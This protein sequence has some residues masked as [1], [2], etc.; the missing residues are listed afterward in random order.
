MVRR[1]N[2]SGP[3]KLRFRPVLVG[4][5]HPM[6]HS[7]TGEVG[8]FS[9]Q[10]GSSGLNLRW[11]LS[12][13]CKWKISYPIFIGEVTRSASLMN[14]NLLQPQLLGKALLEDVIIS[15]LGDK[16]SAPIEKVAGGPGCRSGVSKGR[17]DRRRHFS[18]AASG[19][20][21]LESP[22]SQGGSRSH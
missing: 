5:G 21:A 13:R 6:L 7:F 18:I 17:P 20:E 11:I 22:R 15:H 16:A 19:D 2:V 8:T 9:P 14:G 3:R 10:R 1:R 12:G 4:L